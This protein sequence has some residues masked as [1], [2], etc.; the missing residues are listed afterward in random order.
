MATN[1]PAERIEDSAAGTRLFFEKYG[2]Q[3]LEFPANDVAYTLGFFQSKGFDFDAAN[4]VSVIILRQ[5]KIDSTPISEILDT[6][7][8]FNSIQISR[9]VSEILNNNRTPTSIL[10]YRTENVKNFLA[11]NIVP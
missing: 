2:E 3:E 5:A 4:L 1:L 11:R 9:I 7:K 10:G 6:L 8:G